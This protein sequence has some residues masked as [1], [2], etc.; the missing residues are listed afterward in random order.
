MGEKSEQKSTHIYHIW[1]IS[2]LIEIIS[3][4]FLLFLGI[5]S[6]FIDLFTKNHW[7]LIV[8]F[9]FLSVGTLFYIITFRRLVLSHIG[10]E[11][12]PL[13]P[14]RYRSVFLSV[15]GFYC[16]LF[17]ALLYFFDFYLGWN[18][19]NNVDL[20]MVFFENGLLFIFFISLAFAS[21]NNRILISSIL[22]LIGIT[23]GKLV[24][25]FSSGSYIGQTILIVFGVSLIVIGIIFFKK[26]LSK[27]SD[28][29]FKP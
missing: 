21:K 12:L 2:G 7:D 28:L 22:Y 10:I 14:K 25:F 27:P 26:L 9:L 29:I 4:F 19:N 8:D 1:S 17:I 11:N 3:G 18:L 5:Y 16:I 6:F 20:I 15:F 24:L 23:I 13:P